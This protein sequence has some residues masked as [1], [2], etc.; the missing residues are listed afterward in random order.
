MRIK[1][2]N[3]NVKKMYKQNSGYRELMSGSF[4]VKLTTVRVKV[5]LNAK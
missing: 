4:G 5:A 3:S 1:D 2:Q